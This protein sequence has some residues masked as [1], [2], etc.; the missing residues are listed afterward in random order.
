LKRKYLSKLQ[1]IGLFS[2]VLVLSKIKNVNEFY[3]NTK[4]NNERNIYCP[5]T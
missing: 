1:N 5:I 2:N 3:E 4:D